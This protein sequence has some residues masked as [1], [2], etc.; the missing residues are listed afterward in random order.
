[1]VYVYDKIGEEF[2]GI[3]FGVV[4]FGLFVKMMENVC[5]GMVLL[6]EILGDWFYF[7]VKCMVIEGKESGKIY[8][9]GD[10]V[11]VWIVEVYLKKW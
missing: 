5:E 6:M 4:E 1:M 9:F 3:V 10:L 7:D 2:D 8:S 11:K